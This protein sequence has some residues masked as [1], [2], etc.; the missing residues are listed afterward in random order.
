MNAPA[1]RPSIRHSSSYS[2]HSYADGA[3]ARRR[4]AACA[5][6]RITQC[7]MVR[8]TTGSPRGKGSTHRPPAR[9]AFRD[10]DVLAPNQDTG[11]DRGTH[12]STPHQVVYEGLW[13]V[14]KPAKLLNRSSS[15]MSSSMTLTRR[16]SSFFSSYRG[17]PSQVRGMRDGSQSGDGVWMDTTVSHSLSHSLT[18][19][20]ARR[21][22]CDSPHLATRTSGRR[23]RRS[24]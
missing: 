7:T 11:L 6:G 3:P 22:P 18:H 19:P 14:G 15:T 23:R 12:A 21:C 9:Y 16:A 20:L 1:S 13:R 5:A 17:S 2:S 4:V 24:I 10:S 8:S